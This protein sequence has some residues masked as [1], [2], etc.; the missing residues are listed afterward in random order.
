MQGY[1]LCWNICLIIFP[2]SVFHHLPA[3]P[4]IISLSDKRGRINPILT[5]LK[6]ASVHWPKMFLSS[7]KMKQLFH[8]LAIYHVIL[9]FKY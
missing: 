3:N 7:V 4:L 2:F 8:L 1:D 9:S 6:D 5:Y